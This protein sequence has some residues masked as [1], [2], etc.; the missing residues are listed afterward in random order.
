MDYFSTFIFTVEII[1]R[2]IANGFLCNG[3]KSYMKQTSNIIDFFIVVISIVSLFPSKVHI[4]YFKIIRMARLL[5][6]LRVISKNE[7]LKLSMQALWIAVPAIISLLVI[8]ILVLLIFSIIGINLLKGHSYYCFT[9]NLDLSQREIE[10]LINDKD[11][12]LNYGGLWSR[13]H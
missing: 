12:C 13:N 3:K 5:R 8:V 11:D 4:S 10:V 7:N 9:E 6:P 2:V 1:I